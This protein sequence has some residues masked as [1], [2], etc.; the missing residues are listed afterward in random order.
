MKRRELIRHITFYGCRFLREGAK[1]TVFFNPQNRRTST[2]PRHN[3]IINILAGKIC[4][5]LEIPEP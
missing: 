4:R 5:D 1:H 3:E 2:M